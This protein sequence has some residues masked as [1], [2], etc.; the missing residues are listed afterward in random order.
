MLSEDQMKVIREEEI[1]REEVRKN[2]EKKRESESQK[3]GLWRFVNSSFGLWLLSSVVLSFL[4]FSYGYVQDQRRTKRDAQERISKLQYE[5][6]AHGSDFLNSLQFAQN[7]TDYSNQ[8]VEHLQRPKYKLSEFKDATMDQL[9][10]EY[11]QLAND[12]KKANSVQGAINWIWADV[13]SMNQQLTLGSDVKQ[14][15]DKDFNDSV[16]ELLFPAVDTQPEK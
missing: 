9:V 15:F 2:I 10:W 4:G 16:N 7:Y 12:R 6:A 1:F 8:F 13:D 14:W 3:G 5:I 11:K